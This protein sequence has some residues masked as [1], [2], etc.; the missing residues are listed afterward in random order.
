MACT[1]ILRRKYTG[2][3]SLKMTDHCKK[4]SLLPTC[5][6]KISPKDCPKPQLTIFDDETFLLELS[7]VLSSKECAEIINNADKCIFENVSDKYRFGMQRNSSRLLVLDKTLAENLWQRVYKV[8]FREIKDKGV[9]I[10]PL[11]FDVTRG[12]WDL[13]SLNEAIRINK[14]SEEEKGFFGPHKDAQ[15][16]PNG[17]QRSIMTLLIYLNEDFKGGETCFYFP[18][19]STLSSKAMTIKEEINLHGGLE[20]GY[21]LVR[22]VPK[23]GHAVLSSQSIL[24]EALPVSNGTKYI[25]KTDVVVKRCAKEFGFAVAECEKKDYMV[26]LNYFRE[27]QQ[28]ELKHHFDVASD[29]YEKALSIRYCYPS[30][31]KEKPKDIDTSGYTRF[32]SDVWLHVFNFLSGYDVQNIVYAYPELNLVMATWEQTQRNFAFNLSKSSVGYLPTIRFQKGMVTSFVFPDAEFFKENKS[33]CC[34]VAAMYS[35]FLLGHSPQ[36]DTYTVRYNPDTQEVCVVAL[37]TL[38]ADV[39][40]GRRCYGSVYNV[41]QQDPQTRDPKKDFEASVDRSYML[42]KHGAEFTGVELPDSFCTKSV[43]HI[44]SDEE[45][46]DD[47]GGSDDDG[48]NDDDGGGCNT[49]G[50]ANDV[51]CS[52][53]DDGGSNDDDGGCNTSSDAND[54]S[55]SS[56]DDGSKDDGSDDYMTTRKKKGV[57]YDDILPYYGEI[58]ENISIDT[59]IQSMLMVASQSNALSEEV[60]LR[61]N[62]QKLFDDCQYTDGARQYFEAFKEPMN[63]SS[64]AVVSKLDTPINFEPGEACICFTGP[65]ERSS[66]RLATHCSTEYFNY[67]VFDFLRSEFNVKFLDSSCFA[68]QDRSG[69]HPKQNEKAALNELGKFGCTG[70]LIYAKVNIE[71]ILSSDTSFNHAACQCGHPRF[72]LKQHYNLKDY[73]HLTS[74]TVFAKEKE[75]QMITSTIYN[76]IVAL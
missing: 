50:D 44:T 63:G 23:V 8:L 71:P 66:Y 14:Y 1:R 47:G 55:C 37:E 21:K 16:C 56:D 40:Y 62:V 60:A 68:E 76:G 57:Y 31:I 22:I 42:M 73:V 32:P 67:L 20:N 25:L 13:D 58:D 43:V 53:D 28:Q 3:L 41:Q 74:V 27:A 59:V 30:G 64:A 49:G 5:T 2:N 75:G 35:F 34:R 24:H 26:C 17:D 70:E 29:L 12:V 18:K 11:G 48:G 39:F 45:G 36:D 61:E 51:G 65:D 38:L 72:E 4:T 54:V 15:F 9:S 33:E 10:Q 46:C 52:S 19:D 7:N 69:W 6:L